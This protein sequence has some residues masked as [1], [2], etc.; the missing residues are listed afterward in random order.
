MHSIAMEQ[1]KKVGLVLYA[2]DQKCNVIWQKNVHL[3]STF[4]I[5][6]HV[7]P[8]YVILYIFYTLKCCMQ[9]RFSKFLIPCYYISFFTVCLKHLYI[10]K[11]YR[12]SYS[13]PYQRQ[14][15]YFL[16]KN[17]L[18]GQIHSKANLFNS[19]SWHYRTGAF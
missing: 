1:R 6:G 12:W 7:V 17:S 9:C 11:Y 13:Y 15:E 5:L 3:H 2:I 19:F 14:A 10:S 18:A 8:S 16:P 4:D